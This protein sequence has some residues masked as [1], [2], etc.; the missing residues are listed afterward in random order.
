MDQTHKGEGTLIVDG[1]E[2]P[3]RY[4][5]DIYVD[6]RMKTGEGTVSAEPQVLW[7]AFNKQK[8]RCRMSD[9]RVFPL[10]ITRW[11]AG[12]NVAAFR[13]AGGFEGE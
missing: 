10:I 3:C 6:R 4:H 12:S 11:G 2:H 5:L 9:G 7:D 8:T 1:E 13:M